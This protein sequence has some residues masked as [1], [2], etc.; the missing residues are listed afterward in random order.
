MPPVAPH[1]S[2]LAP[3]SLLGECDVRRGRV[4]GPG[5]QNR[6]KVETAI[7]LRHRPTGVEAS[8]TERRSQAENLS[9]AVSRLRLNLSVEVRYPVDPAE[10][11]SDLWKS[12][13]RDGRIVVSAAHKDFP[14][15]LAEAL[16]MLA[17]AG[18]DP[19]AAAAAMGCSVSQFIK[20]LKDEPRALS[21]LNAH[22]KRAGLR[23]MW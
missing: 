12:R 5:G 8:A 18:M 21:W 7:F 23:P 22:R 17:A 11:A 20:L 19:A 9:K 3:E 2:R 1:P 13:L 14:A 4:S 15:I 10:P 16:D 6:N